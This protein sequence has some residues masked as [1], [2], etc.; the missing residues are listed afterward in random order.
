MVVLSFVTT[1]VLRAIVRTG[2][3][4]SLI[5]SLL[6]ASVWLHYP[7]SYSGWNFHFC[8]LTLYFKFFI[9]LSHC[10]LDSEL[11]SPRE[12]EISKGCESLVKVRNALSK[13]KL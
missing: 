13:E 10:F 8:L 4:T 1:V 11:Q 3:L 9:H 12:V 6:S 7:P 2:D 5:C